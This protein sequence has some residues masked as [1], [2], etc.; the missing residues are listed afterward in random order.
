MSQLIT[1]LLV[2]QI[3]LAGGLSK[4]EVSNNFTKSLITVSYVLMK[5]L[6][7]QFPYLL[8]CHYLHINKTIQ[9]SISTYFAFDNALMVTLYTEGSS[10]IDALCPL[11]FAFPI[12]AR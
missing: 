8:M 3:Y 12:F 5:S 1:Y 2:L 6:G 9:T 4:G 7:V 11:P 10:D